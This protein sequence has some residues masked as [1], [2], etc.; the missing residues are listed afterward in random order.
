MTGMRM[1]RFRPL[2]EAGGWRRLF[3]AGSLLLAVA[4]FAWG[5]HVRREDM[6]DGDYIEYVLALWS[7]GSVALGL[8]I[9]G[10]ALLDGV[11]VWVGR[12]FGL[13]PATTRMGLVAV[14]AGLTFASTAAIYLRYETVMPEGGAM[15]TGELCVV[16]DRW[17]GEAKP[18]TEEAVTRRHRRHAEP[19]RAQ[20]SRNEEAAWRQIIGIVSE[21]MKS[22]NWL[23][24][25]TS[26]PGVGAQFP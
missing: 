6:S 7:L 26:A 22:A 4:A 2:R 13:A 8:L 20:E 24:V 3:L 21:L 10:L 16:L 25:M 12:G 15:R 23:P 17:T 5:W 14:L 19:Q 18:C 1:L 9:G 11:C